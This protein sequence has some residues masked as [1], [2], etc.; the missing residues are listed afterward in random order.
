MEAEIQTVIGLFTETYR[1]FLNW[2]TNFA[3]WTCP[4]WKKRHRYGLY[5]SAIQL[6][7]KESYW[8]NLTVIKILFMQ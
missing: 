4:K 7:G 2:T 5:L 6:E 3:T 1:Q 8:S